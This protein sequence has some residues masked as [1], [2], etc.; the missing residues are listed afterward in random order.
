MSP[1][2]EGFCEDADGSS[3][4]A[5]TTQPEAVLR[6]LNVEVP[7]EVY[8]HIRKCATESRLSLKHYMAKFGRE[9]SAYPPKDVSIC[10]DNTAGPRIS[11]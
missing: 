4:C 8:W 11:S 9:A 5:E 2:A 6:T 7:E 3:P 1:G 10:E